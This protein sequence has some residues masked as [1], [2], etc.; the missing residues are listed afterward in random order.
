MQPSWP[1][2][3][4]ATAQTFETQTF[5][6][7]GL[8]TWTLAQAPVAGL[9]RGPARTWVR[10]G[11]FIPSCALARQPPHWGGA[12]ASFAGLPQSHH[13]AAQSSMTSISVCLRGDEHV[14]LPET[15]TCVIF[16]TL[17]NSY[18]GV[19]GQA[20]ANSSLSRSMAKKSRSRAMKLHRGQCWLSSF[21]KGV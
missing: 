2:S 3:A 4:S 12:C 15:H 10:G 6:R 18:D 11:A 17:F 13:E 19:A 1:R 5:E 9:R 8:I 7:L 14:E 16:T 21:A 20:P